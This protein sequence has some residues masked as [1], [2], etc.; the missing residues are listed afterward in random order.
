MILRLDR[1]GE[2]GEEIVVEDGPPEGAAPNDL[3]AQPDVFAPGYAPEEIA[4]IA[5][6][7]RESA[8]VSK[9]ST[10]RKSKTRPKATTGP[11]RS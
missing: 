9:R 10:S 8:G 1:V 11:R 6:K 7:L 3:P 5:S 2:T 4:Q